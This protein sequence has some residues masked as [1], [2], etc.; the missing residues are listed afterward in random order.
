[1]SY[2]YDVLAWNVATDSLVPGLIPNLQCC[3][4]KSVKE[5][6]YMKSC[7]EDI[8]SIFWMGVMLISVTL[9]LYA[10]WTIDDKVAWKVHAQKN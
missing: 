3:M 1:M 9:D 10:A 8:L 6:Q 2:V 7:D 4:L 5:D